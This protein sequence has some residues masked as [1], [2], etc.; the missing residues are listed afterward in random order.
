MPRSVVIQSANTLSPWYVVGFDFDRGS[1][2]WDQPGTTPPKHFQSA[3]HARVFLKK[4]NH[5]GCGVLI[6]YASRIAP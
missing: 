4:A 3:A 2:V 1:I 6:P 5:S